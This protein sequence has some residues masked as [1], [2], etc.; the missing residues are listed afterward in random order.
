M[1]QKQVYQQLRQAGIR[2]EKDLRNEKLNFKIREYSAPHY[3]INH[4]LDLIERD[5]LSLSPYH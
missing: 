3:K 5:R 2:I 1:N 4:S